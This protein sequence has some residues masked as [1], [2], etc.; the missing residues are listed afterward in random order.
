MKAV[1]SH[2]CAEFYGEYNEYGQCLAQFVKF[3]ERHDICTQNPRPGSPHQNSV[4][5]SVIVINGNGYD[6]TKL[7]IFTPIY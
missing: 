5:Q 6:Y 7:F 1:K 4:A 2:R 3:L